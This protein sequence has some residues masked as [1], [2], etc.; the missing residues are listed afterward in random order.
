MSLKGSIFAV[1][2]TLIFPQQTWAKEGVGLQLKAD[3]IRYLQ[4]LRSQNV[5][6]LREIDQTLE[7]KIEISKPTDLEQDVRALRVQKR[8]HM[9]R[10][11]FL[12][13][14]IFQVDTKFVGGDL[15][16]FFEVT[17]TEMAKIDA[18]T[19]AVDTG[20]WKFMKFAADAVR[21]LP[22]QKE[23]IVS[24]IEGYMNRSISNPIRPEDYL[25]SRNYTNG[26]A[27][28]AG[29]PLS[30]EEVGAV[31]DRRIREVSKDEID[32]AVAPPANATEV[33]PPQ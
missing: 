30:R 1:I 9:L 22:E 29:S 23:N 19:S 13:R 3:T 10:Q 6:R 11:E 27:S 12:D 16:K 25:N 15:R 2:F 17:L 7:Q 14:L 26:A 32:A 4:D 21:R 5:K 8:E 31:A 24:F 18:I 20:L 28:E 33:V